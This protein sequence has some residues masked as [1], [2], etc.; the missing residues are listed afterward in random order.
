MYFFTYRKLLSYEVFRVLAHFWK[1]FMLKIAFLKV[2]E[3]VSEVV[4]DENLK[5]QP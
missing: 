2:S 4:S 5:K 3:I 1:A